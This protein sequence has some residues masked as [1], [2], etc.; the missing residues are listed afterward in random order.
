M[1]S[2]Y[3]VR[4]AVEELHVD[5]DPELR[6]TGRRDTRE[7]LTSE[8]NK[9]YKTTGNSL[10]KWFLYPPEYFKQTLISR[11]KSF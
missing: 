7:C 5:P 9:V 1:R 8:E 2:H 11:I 6:G 3:R 4:S 10:T